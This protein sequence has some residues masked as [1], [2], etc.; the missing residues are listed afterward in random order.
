MVDMY[1]HTL[2][3]QCSISKFSFQDPL[4]SQRVGASPSLYGRMRAGPHTL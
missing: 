1:A 4:A 2:S 3:V